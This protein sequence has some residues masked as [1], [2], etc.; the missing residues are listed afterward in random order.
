MKDL[1][2]AAVCMRAEL[3]DIRRNLNKIEEFALQAANRGAQVVC[4]PELT[5][6][7]YALKQPVRLYGECNYDEIVAHILSI[8]RKSRVILLVGLVEPCE[9]QRPFVAHMIAGPRGLLGWYRKTH[10]SSLESKAYQPGQGVEV[11][12]IRQACLGIQLCYEA[13]FPEISTIMALRG[14]EILFVPHASPRGNPLEKRSNWLRHLPA[15]A[16]DNAVF[17]VAC[18]QVG[19][20]REGLEFPGVVVF[21]GPDG[22]VIRSYAGKKEG[23]I[24]ADMKGAEI[25]RMRSHRM[26]YFLPERRTELYG[27]LLGNGGLNGVTNKTGG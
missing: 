8:A 20:N 3:G 19:R 6:T 22:R 15:R 25:K 21:L 16:L 7:G 17:V 24:L 10:L 5:V 27:P 26:R 18:N 2:V 11:F 9:N 14:A 12:S 4:Y 23:I 1:R 13:H